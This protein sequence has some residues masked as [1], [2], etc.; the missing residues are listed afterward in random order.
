MV[1]K[2]SSK[3]TKPIKKVKTEKK[4]KTSFVLK[5]VNP[6]HVIA[7]TYVKKAN[8]ILDFKDEKNELPQTILPDETV[9]N[10]LLHEESN[11]IVYFLD[12]KKNQ[13]KVWPNFYDITKKG[14]L[15][16][17]AT[18]K[19]CWWDRSGFSTRPIGCPIAYHSN[20]SS[21]KDSKRFKTFLK[22]SGFK[23]EEKISEFFETEG[24]FCSF[25]CVKA[26]IKENITKP[27]LST[28]Y[29]ESNTLLTLLYRLLHGKTSMCVDIPTAPSW[30]LLKEYGGHLTIR[31]FR[32]SFGK[33]QYEET[34]NIRRPLMFCSS[35][36]IKEIKTKSD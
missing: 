19:K 25:P 27:A 20:K 24:I 22:N 32:D 34:L 36:Y 26:Y 8:K 35:Q 28:I 15:P 21:G 33:L 7:T 17:V 9:V 6:F 3:K 14:P 16:N 1:K 11:D 18:S 2:I 12:S 10:D 4:V 30:K 23:S 5:G 31:E 29:K 13:I